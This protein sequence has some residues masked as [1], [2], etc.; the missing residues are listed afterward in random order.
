MSPCKHDPIP[1]VTDSPLVDLPNRL[2]LTE[3]VGHTMQSS[4]LN[5]HPSLHRTSS[6][7][8]ETDS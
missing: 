8:A 1:P 5:A 6:I 3:A 7:P 4:S 2:A